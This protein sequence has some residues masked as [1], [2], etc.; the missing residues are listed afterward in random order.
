MA[1]QAESWTM[2]TPT[3]QRATA[4]WGARNDPDDFSLPLAMVNAIIDEMATMVHRA[5]GASQSLNFLI[6]LKLKQNSVMDTQ[7]SLK[8]AQEATRQGRIVLIFTLTTIVLLPLSFMTS[9]FTLNIGQFRTNAEGQL[10]LGYVSYI[11][12]PISSLISAALIWTVVRF[13]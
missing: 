7:E 8:M 4:I 5:E 2:K 3:A 9:F 12:F 11:I 1:T 10:E 6:G 13:Q